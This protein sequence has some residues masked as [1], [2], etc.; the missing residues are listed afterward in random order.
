M[1]SF[2]FIAIFVLINLELQS[3]GSAK[4]TQIQK[5]TNQSMEAEKLN[6]L[7]ALIEEN[8]DQ[9]IEKQLQEALLLQ[10]SDNEAV[11]LKTNEELMRLFSGLE[12][13]F[14]ENPKI[15]FYY[16]TL[17]SNHYEKLLEEPEKQQLSLEK[18]NEASKII[19]LNEGGKSIAMKYHLTGRKEKNKVVI[20]IIESQKAKQLFVI[21]IDYTISKVVGT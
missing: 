4:N 13:K 1:F 8:T 19:I 12:K 21:P 15:S 6:L 11:K 10:Q 9:L 20:A 18:L 5:A 14:K 3:I 7:Q 2:A 16:A 17:N